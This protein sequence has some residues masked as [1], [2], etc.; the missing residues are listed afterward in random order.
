MT[1]DRYR[2][3]SEGVTSDKGP[4]S[5]HPPS[6]KPKPTARSKRLRAKAKANRWARV[7]PLTLSNF[8]F[9]RTRSAERDAEKASA[10]VQGFQATRLQIRSL[11]PAGGKV[12]RAQVSGGFPETEDGRQKTGGR[13]EVKTPRRH[14]RDVTGRRAHPTDDVCPVS[15]TD[16]LR[17]LPEGCRRELPCAGLPCSPPAWSKGTHCRLRDRRKTATGSTRLYV[18]DRRRQSVRIHRSAKPCSKPSNPDVRADRSSGSP[19]A[20]GNFLTGRLALSGARWVY[21]V[22]MHVPIFRRTASVSFSHPV[23][24]CSIW[25]WT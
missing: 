4:A 9:P 2:I 15:T 10:D 3:R 7:S 22:C 18:G 23:C 13:G 14:T 19:S 6:P 20:H 17:P 25:T 21:L 1:D 11:Q 12:R 24:A 8:E 5:S 16:E